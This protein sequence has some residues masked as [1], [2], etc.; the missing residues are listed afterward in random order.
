MI[1]KKSK[2]LLDSVES[3]IG[4]SAIIE[5]TV[6]TDKTVR[7]D[8][9]IINGNIIAEGVIVGEKAEITGDIDTKVIVIAGLIK[10]NINAS[11]TIEIL[12]QAKVFGDIKTNILTIAEGAHFYGKSSMTIKETT[13]D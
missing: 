10:G 9:K 8:G 12:P 6:K 5:G 3:L 4:H 11:E 2:S 7:I 1:K 13:V